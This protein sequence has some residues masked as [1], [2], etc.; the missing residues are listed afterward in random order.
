MYATKSCA[1]VCSMCHNDAAIMLMCRKQLK[2]G[3]VLK[4]ST[5]DGWRD[6]EGVGA[7]QRREGTD[8][9]RDGADVGAT[10]REGTE[11]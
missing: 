1:A 9:W 6:G 11:G 2:G 3:R 10:R 4:D 5:T 7:T 8:G